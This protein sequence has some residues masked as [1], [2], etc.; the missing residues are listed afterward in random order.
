MRIMSTGA[1][2]YIGVRARAT[3]GG[4]DTVQF[5]NVKPDPRGGGYGPD[6]IAPPY[7]LG[8]SFENAEKNH[9]DVLLTSDENVSQYQEDSEL[10]VSARLLAL[11]HGRI[12]TSHIQRALR[13]GY[14]RAARLMDMLEENGVIGPA[15]GS[16]PRETISSAA[17]PPPS[18]DAPVMVSPPPESSFA[19][20]LP[21]FIGTDHPSLPAV[22]PTSFFDETGEEVKQKAFLP[23][24]LKKGEYHPAYIEHIIQYFDQPKKRE[25]RDYFTYKSGAESEKVRYVP[26]PPPQFSKYARSIGVTTKKLQEWGE[27]HPEFGEALGICQEI[28]EEFLIEN[29]LTGEYGAIM[30][31]FVAVNKTRMRDKTEHTEKK[32]N[33]NEALDQIAAGQLQ[34][35]GMLPAGTVRELPFHGAL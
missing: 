5:E 28:F 7:P 21:A 33:I 1:R 11:E 9:S 3:I 12:S 30:T 15:V 20:P 18:M 17:V 27:E 35:G 29:G 23:V 6:E 14:S 19:V 22:H 25:V 8:V 10:Y 26:N 2:I 32:V 4:M 16:A 24:G 13:I 34:P 31:K